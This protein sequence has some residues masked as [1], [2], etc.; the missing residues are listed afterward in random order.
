MK[1]VLCFAAAA[2]AI[3]ASCQKT[4]VVYSNDGPQEIALFAVNKTATKAPVTSTA[5]PGENTMYVAAYLASSD[6]GASQTTSGDYFNGTSFEKPTDGQYW[7]GG[8]YWP[9]TNSKLNFLAVS[10]HAS[11]PISTVTFGEDNK[12]YAKKAVVVL[13]DNSSAQH[14]LMYAAALGVHTVSNND[15]ELVNMT[16]KHALSWINFK[17]AGTEDVITVN[18]ITLNNASY[19]G[20]LTLDNS[21]NYQKSAAY[22]TAPR[23]SWSDVASGKNVAV[24][25]DAIDCTSS[26]Q[27]FGSNGLLVIP[28]NATTFTINYTIKHG[29]TSNTFDY[30]YTCTGIW[31]MGKKYTY[32][33]NITPALI[34]INPYVQNWNADLNDDSNNTNDDISVPLA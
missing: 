27:V 30:T 18:R 16:F 19:A 15:N 6:I 25:A 31:E 20:T 32:S 11:A 1:K 7:T 12:D 5:Y 13:A 2:M 22:T 33:V 21:E 8:K 4:E 3:F 28:G 14:D 9:V 34:Q 26:S 23:A 29:G 24:I 17:V 10:G